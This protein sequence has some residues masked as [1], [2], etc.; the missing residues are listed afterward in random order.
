[1]IY[2][3]VT[4]K[5]VK[6]FESIHSCFPNSSRNGGSTI[7][8]F[9]LINNC[10]KIHKI[11]YLPSNLLKTGVQPKNVL[12]RITIPGEAFASKFSCS[13]PEDHVFPAANV[14]NSSVHVSVRSLPRRED[15]PNV[16]CPHTV[17]TMPELTLSPIP[18]SGASSGEF[19]YVISTYRVFT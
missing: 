13:Q 12:Y 14:G 19:F 7:H 18:A 5:I 11:A 8:R 2:Q 6:H 15:I 9:T 16:R 4:L 3:S 10:F 1:M 17:S